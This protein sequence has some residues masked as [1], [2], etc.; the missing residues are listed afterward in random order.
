MQTPTFM[1]GDYL[2]VVSP[3]TVDGV[4]PLLDDEGKK[5]YKETFL[6]ITAKKV[7]EERN[8]KLPEYLKKKIEVVSSGPAQAPTSEKPGNQK[9]T[10]PKLV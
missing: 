1:N 5:V 3:I 7:I 8:L 4:Q 2:R 6:P 10:V 9:R